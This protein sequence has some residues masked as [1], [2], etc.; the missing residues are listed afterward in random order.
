MTGKSS[1]IASLVTLGASY[2]SDDLAA[3]G[4]DGRVHP[5]SSTI[6]LRYPG[7]GA[8]V[9]PIAEIGGRMAVEPIPIG[10]VA[11]TKY[12]S[13]A[14]WKP[15]RLSP[16]ETMMRLIDNTLLARDRKKLMLQIN[17]MVS[18][19]AIAISSPRGDAAKVAPHLLTWLETN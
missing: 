19:H 8:R 5:Y 6:S 14:E 7:E 16:G 17:R 18:Q 12:Q 13:G 4:L 3:I 10:L 1:L 11:V 2:Y 9:L 15:Q